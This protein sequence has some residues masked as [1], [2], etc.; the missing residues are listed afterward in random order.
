MTLVLQANCGDEYAILTGDLMGRKYSNPDYFERGGDKG[1]PVEIVLGIQK[2]ARVSNL[3]LAGTAGCHDLGTWLR[4]DLQ[5]QAGSG[6]DL[7]SCMVLAG[8]IIES[9]KSK[10]HAREVFGMEPL[11]LN[12]LYNPYCFGFVLTGFYK[13]GGTGQVVFHSSPEGGSF[14]EVRSKGNRSY[15][16]F[17]PAN[18]YKQEMD[19]FFDLKGGPP[20]IT[21]TLAQ[22]TV[23]HHTLSGMLPEHISGQMEILILERKKRG[24]KPGFIKIDVDQPTIEGAI[25]N[26]GLVYASKSLLCLN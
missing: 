26:I 8:R 16:M 21:S 23:L 17:T 25:K 12:H 15:Y 13:G 19:A 4:K 18:N 22:M 14:K 1:D 10:K 24:M 11:Y 20:V 5:A 9:M 7:A 2:V 6:D 3:V